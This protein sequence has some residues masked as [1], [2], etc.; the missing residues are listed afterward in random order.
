MKA[1][2]C[3][4]LR[5]EAPFRAE[6]P[7]TTLSSSARRA[8]A[9]SSTTTARATNY[10]PTEPPWRHI[11]GDKTYWQE[12]EPRHDVRVEHFYSYAQ[13]QQ[14]I[15]AP[16]AD[17][18]PEK[19]VKR[20][21]SEMG[22]FKP[23]GSPVMVAKKD[24][25]GNDT[26][27]QVTLPPLVF[28]DTF[29][30]VQQV[31]W[32]P[33]KPEIIA[34]QL[35]GGGAPVEHRGAR[36]FNQYRPPD[37]EPGDA[38][39]AKPCRDLLYKLWPDTANHVEKYLAHCVQHPAVKI[40]HALVLAGPP[41]IGKDTLLAAV[42]WTI[43]PWNLQVIDPP[44]FVGTFNG[45]R[46]S[47]MLIIGEARDQGYDRYKFYEHCK[48]MFATPPD[49]LRVNEKNLREYYVPNVFA[50]VITT[51]HLVGGIYLPA[52][53]RRHHV[54]WSTVTWEAFAT[55]AEIT[56]ITKAGVDGR[57]AP[58]PA[59]WRRFW[60]WLHA[61]GFRHVAAY[62]SSLDLGDFDPKAPPPKTEA[63]RVIVDA[64][65]G[66]EES[67][68]AD[69][70]DTMQGLNGELPIAVSLD[71]AIAALGSEDDRAWFTDRQN[72]R[73]LPFIFD[74]CGYAPVRNETATDGRWKL[75]RR[76]C[77]VY[78]RKDKTKREILEFIKQKLRA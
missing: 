4:H 27:E 28:L 34:D 6:Q 16:S 33:G 9:T 2:G 13:S 71:K 25:E 21:L 56:A 15:F 40:N 62:L 29:R 52:D 26:E 23:D 18:W 48:L 65:R 72:F 43:G 11:N 50:P 32:W 68:L 49:M 31:T 5:C 54:N 42:T 14:Y 39:K 70:L 51:N 36:V 74:R 41:G 24:A 38:A 57:P 19:R 47:V 53:D 3:E 75:G 46:K 78:G 73:R 20:L 58:T 59:F 63:F 12:L 8:A 30:P 44:A 64:E 76:R 66:V 35:I 61:E 55:E 60:A 67:A 1:N 10:W 45:W 22:L 69:A 7:A 77:V 37:F 17:L